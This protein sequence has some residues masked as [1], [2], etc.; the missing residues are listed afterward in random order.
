MA[1][2]GNEFDF[3]KAKSIEL[4]YLHHV[5]TDLVLSVGKI[6]WVPISVAILSIHE[7]MGSHGFEILRRMIQLEAW[8]SPD[9][10]R[11]NNWLDS[12]KT[13][14]HTLRALSFERKPRSLEERKAAFRHSEALAYP[15]PSLAQIYI[16][17]R[18]R[19]VPSME[20][21]IYWIGDDMGEDYWLDPEIAVSRAFAQKAFKITQDF[22]VS[23]FEVRGFEINRTD[24]LIRLPG[25][26]PLY[27]REEPIL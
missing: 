26:Q 20:D 3:T 21:D 23:W 19:A 4:G 27:I 7:G 5:D 10:A 24:R 12:N 1:N 11:I 18:Q 2:N 25:Y 17:S 14:L 8:V 16:S 15:A 13:C 6:D 9:D 22:A